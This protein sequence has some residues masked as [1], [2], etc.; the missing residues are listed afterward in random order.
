MG[1]RQAQ[2]GEVQVIN[3]HMGLRGQERLN[4]I[5][6]LL[7]PEW[8]G[9]PRCADPVILLGDFNAA[10]RS[11]AYRRVAA[12]LRDA[13]TSP[14]AARAQATF[15]SRMPMLRIDHVFVSGG[16]EVTRAETD[17]D[18]AGPGRVGPPAAAGGV[19]ADP[20]ELPVPADRGRAGR[21]PPGGGGPR[22]TVAQDAGAAPQARDEARTGARTPAPASASGRASSRSRPWRCQPS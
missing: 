21:A 11:R 18:A 17:P 5:E 22:M 8:L 16:V 12:R 6:A 2:G 19:P 9:H 1:R 15:P 13:Q 20:A 14:A 4:Q 7:G 10:P 3:T